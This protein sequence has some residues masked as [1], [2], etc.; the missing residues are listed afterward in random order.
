MKGLSPQQLLSPVF[1]RYKITTKKGEEGY[2]F[3][4]QLAQ[5]VG[6]G[7]KDKRMKKGNV[8]SR[9]D[10]GERIKQVPKFILQS[11]DLYHTVRESPSVH[12]VSILA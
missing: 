8:G 3:V 6:T 11:S 10:T 2:T 4:S 7:L 9:R 12:L 5:Q 1:I